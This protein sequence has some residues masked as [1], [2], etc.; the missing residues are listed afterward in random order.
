MSF[1]LD[2]P[3]K[4]LLWMNGIAHTEPQDS[5]DVGYYLLVD[6]APEGNT[7]D[8]NSNYWENLDT[9][10]LVNLASGTHTIGVGVSATKQTSFWIWGEGGTKTCAYYLVLGA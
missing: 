8:V 9:T 4:V 10:R 7:I 3:G 5:Q 1:T 2:Q 6:G